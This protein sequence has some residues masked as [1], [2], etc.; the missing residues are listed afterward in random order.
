M[1][2]MRGFFEG[3]VKGKCVHVVGTPATVKVAS[4]E[5]VVFGEVG[6]L[7]IREISKVVTYHVEI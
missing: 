1:L 2:G 5:G 6:V 3:A 4:G 7:Q